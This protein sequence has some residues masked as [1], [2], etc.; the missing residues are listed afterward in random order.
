MMLLYDIKKTILGLFHCVL[1][2]LLETC[3]YVLSGV[4]ENTLRIFRDLS[5]NNYIILTQT[6]SWDGRFYNITCYTPLKIRAAAVH[7]LHGST[8]L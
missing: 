3:E 6:L 8:Y 7:Y 5:T 1:L 2:S 4:T